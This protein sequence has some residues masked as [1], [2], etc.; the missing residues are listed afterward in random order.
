M[1]APLDKCSIKESVF[2]IFR[3]YNKIN[4]A[5][6]ISKTQYMYIYRMDRFSLI[7]QLIVY[8]I[9]KLSRKSNL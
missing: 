2:I 5:L 6:E 7:V 8:N 9:Y 4:I 3:Y 1:H